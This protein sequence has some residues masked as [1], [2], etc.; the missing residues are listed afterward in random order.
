[1]QI[2]WEKNK[3][4]QMAEL[5]SKMLA[6]KEEQ[7]RQQMEEQLRQQ[8]ADTQEY[9]RTRSERQDALEAEERAKEAANQA[10]IEAAAQGWAKEAPYVEDPNAVGPE[11]PG[12]EI[13]MVNPRFGASGRQYMQALLSDPNQ[14]EKFS[15][16]GEYDRLSDTLTVTPYE[17]G[18]RQQAEY[19]RKQAD[20]AAEQTRKTQGEETKRRQARQERREDKQWEW[21]NRPKESKAPREADDIGRLRSSIAKE[22]AGIAGLEDDL[23]KLDPID[24]KS[25]IPQITARIATRKQKLANLYKKLSAKTGESFEDESEEKADFMAGIRALVNREE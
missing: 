21:A 11:L 13:Q 6:I 7:R 22:E 16:P 25:K 14:L 3:W 24:A 18:Q 5:L 1:M 23:A 10:R 19:E 17:R 9:W 12:Q 8:N 2:I 20:I 4:N 15:Q